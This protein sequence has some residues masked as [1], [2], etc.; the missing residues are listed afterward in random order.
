M[1]TSNT[2]R[3]ESRKLECQLEPDEIR[4]KAESLAHTVKN[5]ADILA[6]K[7]EI[8]AGFKARLEECDLVITQCSDAINTGKEERDVECTVMLNEPKDGTKTICR[9]DTADSWL[10]PMTPAECQEEIF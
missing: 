6:E 10:E 8:M 2:E 5:R 1:K 4:E 3:T 9:K 7:K